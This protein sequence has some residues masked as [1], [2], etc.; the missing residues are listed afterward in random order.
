MEGEEDRDRGGEG[1]LGVELEDREVK[2]ERLE[3]KELRLEV[4]AEEGLE[5]RVDG[6]EGDGEG[7]GETASER[8]SVG[9]EPK[10][11]CWAGVR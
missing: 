11:D 5:R 8:V 6:G 2:E 4:E 1:E 10:R 7:G 9:I 3:V